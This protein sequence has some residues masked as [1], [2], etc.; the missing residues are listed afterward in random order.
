MRA[1]RGS[2]PTVVCC[3]WRDRI[4][5]LSA[6]RTARSLGSPP[7]FR[8]TQAGRTCASPMGRRRR[9]QR[10]RT[11]RMTSF[12]YNNPPIILAPGFQPLRG[13][14]VGAGSAAGNECLH[15]RGRGPRVGPCSVP[16]NHQPLHRADD[17]SRLGISV[18]PA[19]PWGTPCLQL[20]LVSAR[21]NAMPRTVRRLPRTSKMDWPVTLTRAPRLR[22]TSGG[23]GDPAER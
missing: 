22:C 13:Q 10:R 8:L 7:E 21:H 11:K 4:A 1:V 9:P 3:K 2:D 6:Q 19:A 18:G 12:R 16:V 5:I 23:N 15:A 14:R 20:L 17:P